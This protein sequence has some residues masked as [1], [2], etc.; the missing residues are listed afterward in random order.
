MSL[1]QHIKIF[2]FYF[3]STFFFSTFFFF[4]IGK[5]ISLKAKRLRKEYTRSIPR[6]KEVRHQRENK[7]YPYLVAS[8][9]T[10][11][12]KESVFLYI[13]PNPI[14]KSVQKNGLNI[15]VVPLNIIE[16]PPIPFFPNGPH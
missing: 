11:S 2:F 6:Y 15:L 12:N 4:L 5:V 9:S 13:H 1:R 14:H 7:P 10:K 8:Q 16:G 3:K